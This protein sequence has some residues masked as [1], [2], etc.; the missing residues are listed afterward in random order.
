MPLLI[1]MVLICNVAVL[2]EYKYFLETNALIEMDKKCKS[3]LVAHNGA[4]FD[5]IH[6]EMDVE[7]I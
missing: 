5:T 6:N 3:V 2:Q 1:L 4:C 7:Q